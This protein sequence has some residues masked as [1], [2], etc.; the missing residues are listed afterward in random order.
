[1]KELAAALKAG[2]PENAVRVCG[3]VAT[4]VAAEV[5]TEQGIRVARTAL[6]VRNPG[7]AP[8]AWERK[9]LLQ[10]E[11]SGVALP[12]GEEVDGSL[13]W[14]KPITLGTLCLPCHGG[15]GDIPGPVAA[16]LKER[17]PADAA[18][19]FRDGDLRGAFTVTVP[20][21]R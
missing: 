16:L 15:A 4:R 1:M 17:Y 6:R 5:S 10:W 13:R 20:L 18:T 19:G 3:D 9:V 7:N 2:G 12:F 14:M 11:A 21:R 8:D